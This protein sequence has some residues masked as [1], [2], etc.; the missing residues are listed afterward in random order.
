MLLSDA[1]DT[2]NVV[3]YVR[4]IHGALTYEIGRRI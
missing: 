1:V 4:L 3:F 2:N